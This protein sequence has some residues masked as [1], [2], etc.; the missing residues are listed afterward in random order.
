MSPLLALA[1]GLAVGA[2]AT[3]LIFR[4]KLASFPPIRED[5]AVNV[6]YPGGVPSVHVDPSTAGV[7]PGKQVRWT[8]SSSEATDTLVIVPKQPQSWPFPQPPT[9][10]PSGPGQPIN[11][12]P[13]TGRKN[14]T[15]GYN[16]VL[17]LNTGDLNIDPDI[18]IRDSTHYSL[19]PSEP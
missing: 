10:T 4:L 18:F 15:H 5:I 19:K 16:C 13:V 6:T 2:L 11:G 12:G 8:L 9:T 14:T 7:R 17:K 1:V 3:T